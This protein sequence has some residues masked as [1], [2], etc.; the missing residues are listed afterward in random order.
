MHSGFEES[1]PQR[2]ASSNGSEVIR[3][4]KKISDRSRQHAQPEKNGLVQT[5]LRPSYALPRFPQ[6]G[7][8]LGRG[9]LHVGF[10]CRLPDGQ[11]EALEQ[12]SSGELSAFSRLF[13]ASSQTIEQPINHREAILSEKSLNLKISNIK[14]QIVN[15]VVLCG[16]VLLRA[17]RLPIRLHQVGQNK[18]TKKANKMAQEVHFVVGPDRGVRLEKNE[19]RHEVGDRKFGCQKGEQVVAKLGR[20]AGQ[21]K[22]Y[23]K[24]ATVD[25]ITM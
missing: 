5:H 21:E 20:F 9:P 12:G 13:V 8:W 7:L 19:R 4:I 18:K 11:G 23:L 24:R 14:L 15:L 6:Q 10:V 1:N 2:S 22:R 3:K 16:F 25:E 17:T